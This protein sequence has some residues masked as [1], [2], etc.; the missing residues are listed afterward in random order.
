LLTGTVYVNDDVKSW[1]GK[2]DL[3]EKIM[4]CYIDGKD[5]INIMQMLK[6]NAEKVS[7]VCKGMATSVCT[8][9]LFVQT[10]HRVCHVF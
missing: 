6:H 4:N 2:K 8:K 1:N 9:M 10:M 5:Y 7:F 3:Y